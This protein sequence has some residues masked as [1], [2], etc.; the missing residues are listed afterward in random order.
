MLERNVQP[1]D[2]DQLRTNE[3]RGQPLPARF[4]ELVSG[5]DQE[6]K[7]LRAAAHAEVPCDWGLDLTEGPELL[8]PH[9][10]QA[11]AAAVTARL[12]VMWDLQNGRQAEARDDLLATLAL[13]RNISRDGTLI[14]VLVEI[15]MENI[16]VSTV[17]ENFHQFSP[18]TL[19]QLEDGFAA[20][21]ARGTAAQAVATGERSFY[22]W[23]MRKAKEAQKKHPGDEA[24]AMADIQA[25]YQNAM[26]P[27]EGSSNTVEKAPA[28]AAGSV[29]AYI[30]LLDAMPP[31]YDRVAAILSLP[32]AEYEAQIGPFMAEIR[33]S[34]NPM[35]ANL[36]PAFE[37]CR[38]KEFDILSE[39][40]MLH[41]AVE[42][43]VNGEAAFNAVMDPA[44][45]GPF[46]M[47]RFVFKGV[48]RGFK[49]KSS[50]AGRGFPEVM[51]FVEK[52]GEPFLVYGK[53]AG[54][55]AP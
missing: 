35:I 21:P 29:D 51:I 33:N 6:F 43:K 3:W 41:A 39:L 23:F 14:S 52:D 47:E 1:A 54:E 38:P 24:A 45:D 28:V 30:K 53:R 37:K 31:M 27:S 18:E 13:A 2:R 42:Y 17:A 32:R 9:L 50:Y 7:L 8:L 15:A 26:G 44:G 20:A 49:L 11:K 10:A 19:K 12:R 34:P 22:D 5:Y 48:D 16:V 55:A 25:I 4:G 46:V 40:A 36:F